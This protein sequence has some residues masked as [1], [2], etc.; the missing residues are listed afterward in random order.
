[1]LGNPGQYYLLCLSTNLLQHPGRLNMLTDDLESFLH[2]LA[3]MTLRYIPA[4]DSYGAGHHGRDLGM[5]FDG[6]YQVGGHSEA[7]IHLSHSALEHQLHSVI[8]SRS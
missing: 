3:Q 1:M 6:Y 5:K 4:V 2:V 8:V 7:L